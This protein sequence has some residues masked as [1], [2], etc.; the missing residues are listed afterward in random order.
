[1][2]K[3]KKDSVLENTYKQYKLDKFYMSVIEDFAKDGIV[4]YDTNGNIHNRES[5]LTET[6]EIF[7][8]E[9]YIKWKEAHK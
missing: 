3:N 9:K 5:F 6:K 2:V 7:A 4:I 8:S 1:M